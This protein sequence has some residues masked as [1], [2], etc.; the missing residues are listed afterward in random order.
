MPG[1]QRGASRQRSCER[2][3]KDGLEGEEHPQEG[4]RREDVVDARPGAYLVEEAVAGVVD[5]APQRQEEGQRERGYRR[6]RQ[7]AVVRGA[8]TDDGCQLAEQEVPLADG[9]GIAAQEPVGEERTDERRAERPRREVGEPRLHEQQHGQEQQQ[10]GDGEGRQSVEEEAAEDIAHGLHALIG[11]E[12]EVERRCQAACR[13]A[14]ALQ[15]VGLGDG[16]KEQE[17]RQ[18]KGRV[19]ADDGVVDGHCPEQQQGEQQQDVAREPSA[20]GSQQT[21]HTVPQPARRRGG[22]VG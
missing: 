14:P 3:I 11:A 13:H 20:E 21:R 16:G 12:E 6:G 9:V 10:G 4:F 8:E 18:V 22:S 2:G 7:R 1:E 5:D 17:E 15:R 19:D